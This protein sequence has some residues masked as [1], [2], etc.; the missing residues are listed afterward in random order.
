M[1]E[2]GLKSFRLIVQ[3]AAHSCSLEATCTFRWRYSARSQAVESWNRSG[4]GRGEGKSRLLRAY[5]TSPQA[6]LGLPS[7]ETSQPVELS[8]LSLTQQTLCCSDHGS[9][10]ACKKALQGTH[11]PAEGVAQT[12]TFQLRTSSTL[13]PATPNFQ[14]LDLESQ[15]IADRITYVDYYFFEQFSP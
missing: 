11:S 1:Q 2:G 5:S 10:H 6:N 13:D 3:A 7:R 12:G 15:D 8:L 4:Q 14:P 9:E